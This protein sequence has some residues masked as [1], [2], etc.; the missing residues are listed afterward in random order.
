MDLIRFI[1]ASFGI[2]ANNIYSRFIFSSKYSHRLS[3]KYSKYAHVA[4]N[5]R[6]R[7]NTHLGFSH[8]GEYLL[9]NI[10]KDLQKMRKYLADAARCQ[11]SA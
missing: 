5:I 11:L 4:A 7:A 3:N 8:T 6:F 10:R 9:Q 1:F 2:L